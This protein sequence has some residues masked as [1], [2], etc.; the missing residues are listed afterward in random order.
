[1]PMVA[2]VHEVQPVFAASPGT[3]GI[4]GTLFGV[5]AHKLQLAL[6][7]VS[8]PVVFKDQNG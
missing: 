2:Q 5:T 8:I 1:M 6:A 4:L 7:Q 3:A